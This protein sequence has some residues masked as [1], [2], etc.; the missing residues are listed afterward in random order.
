MCLR[1]KL[2]YILQQTC[3]TFNINV[4]ITKIVIGF[5][6]PNK[7]DNVLGLNQLCMYLMAVTG[8]NGK[9]LLVAIC[10][11][12]SIVLMVVL[13]ITGRGNASDDDGTGDDT[14][15]EEDDEDR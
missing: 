14:A 13:I 12:V 6:L 1:K 15:T 4:I 3:N 7:E 8:D 11:I 9:P 10:L 2:N 5:V